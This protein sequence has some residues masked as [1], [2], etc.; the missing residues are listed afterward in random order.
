MKREGSG[1]YCEW[2]GEELECPCTPR[3]RANKHTGQFKPSDKPIAGIKR[4]ADKYYVLTMG[5]NEMGGR[6]KSAL[7]TY[8]RR[9]GYKVVAE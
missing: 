4:V 3:T 8:A 1:L 5:G 6:N 7:A 9:L 2:C